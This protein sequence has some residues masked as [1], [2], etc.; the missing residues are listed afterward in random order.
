MDLRT[1]LLFGMPR[2]GTTWLGKVFDSHPRTLYRHEPDSF[3]TL[4][5][6]P[7]FPE[8]ADAGQYQA[9][10]RDFVAALPATRSARVTGKLP[11]FPKD[12]QGPRA[13]QLRRFR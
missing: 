13:V 3:G 6:M 10:I 1:I 5:A 12:Y 7:L 2:S 4:D 9:L 11:L 8:L